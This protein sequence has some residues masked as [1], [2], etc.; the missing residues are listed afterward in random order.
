ML[1]SLF[2]F[3]NMMPIYSCQSEFIGGIMLIVNEHACASHLRK[4]EIH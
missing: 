4:I 1:K 2:L 3:D